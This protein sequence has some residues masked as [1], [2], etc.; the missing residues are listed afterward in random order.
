MNDII[1][2]EFEK[3]INYTEYLLYN[4]NDNK[5]KNQWKLRQLINI[6]FIL[7]KYPEKITLL[8]L[9][10]V[11]N[12]D[13]IGKHTIMRIKEILENGYLE[14]IKNYKNKIENNLLQELNE[15][16]G[17]GKITALKLMKQGIISLQDL[18]NK[19]ENNEI[20][21]NNKILLGLK[22]AGKFKPQIPRSEIDKIYHH[23]KK[24]VNNLNKKYNLNDTN[25]FIF[26]ICGSYRR[27]LLISNDIDILLTK[28]DTTNDYTYN[29][30]EIF[31]NK[32]RNKFLVEDITYKS[33]ITKYMGFCK[34][35]DNPVRRIDIR[36]ISYDSYYSALLYFTGSANLNKKMRKIAKELGYKLSE[37]GLEKNNKLIKINSEKDIFD[38]L[39]IPYLEPKFREI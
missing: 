12:I 23:I 30:L 8:N 26:N 4:E 17:V 29:Y 27:E 6:L 14:E 37:Y 36:F 19:I 7:N 11:S 18:K 15:V 5:N 39:N 38:K 16:I 21:V 32:L 1:I 25:K 3:L 10:E 33:Y 34:Y 13:G 24:V 2:K 35:K 28:L 9:K 20:K 22:Y 31:V